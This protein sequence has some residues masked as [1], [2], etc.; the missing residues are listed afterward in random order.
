MVESTDF[1]RLLEAPTCKILQG[2]PDTAHGFVHDKGLSIIETPRQFVVKSPLQP[3]YCL[4]LV[5]FY[6][7]I[8]S[9]LKRP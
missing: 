5:Q 6:P 3:T 7:E 8:N 2:L 1:A 9:P 4:K